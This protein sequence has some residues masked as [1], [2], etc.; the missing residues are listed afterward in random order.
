M[1]KD[2]SLVHY[3]TTA[4]VLS[5]IFYLAYLTIRPFF[6]VIIISA[7]LAAFLSPLFKALERIFKVKELSAFVTLLIFVITITFP[8]VIIARTLYAEATG[9]LSWYTS[10]N[11]VAVSAV[12]DRI[13]VLTGGKLPIDTEDLRGE[14]ANYA[15][16]FGM[17]AGTLAVRTGTFVIDF[18]IVLL[19]MYFILVD[20]ERVKAWIMDTI[21]MDKRHAHTLWNR[22]SDV[23]TLT[24]RGN[25]LIMAI[26]T[27]VGIIGMFIAGTSSPVLLGSLY[28]LLSIVP[29]IG[30]LLVWAPT[31]LTLYIAGNAGSAL[32][33]ILW[34]FITNFL[35]DNYVSPKIIGGSTQMHQIVILFSVL[36]GI[37][38]FGIVGLIVGPTIVALALVALDILK[39]FAHGD[40]A[41]KSKV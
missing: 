36:G 17:Q 31:A 29:T 13:G 28:G 24:V 22:A 38:A 39:E 26:Q 8:A 25:L 20:R 27:V 6:I 41:A 21:P 10:D 7:I 11:G 23:I 33:L 14:I 37:Q 5:I 34:S 19:V 9:F 18:F 35:I 1:K 2:S 3:I 4:L 40:V 12:V 30:T 15:R 32:F 16:Q